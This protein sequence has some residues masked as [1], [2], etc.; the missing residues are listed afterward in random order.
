MMQPDGSWALVSTRCLA[1]SRIAGMRRP[2]P[3]PPPSMPVCRGRACAPCARACAPPVRD[4]TRYADQGVDLPEAGRAI[5]VWLGN[6][7]RAQE[8]QRVRTGYR[9]ALVGRACHAGH[10][11]RSSL[12]QCSL[13]AARTLS[14]RLSAIAARI[15]SVVRPPRVGLAVG[16]NRCTAAP[17][18]SRELGRSVGSSATSLAR[19]AVRSATPSSTR[20]TRPAR[21]RSSLPPRA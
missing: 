8:A 14:R 17:E 1:V 3:P 18:Y 16:H 12:A 7:S 15:V 20:C 4:V 13:P 2:S 19:T 9:S 11:L 10:A 5:E 21:T 6:G